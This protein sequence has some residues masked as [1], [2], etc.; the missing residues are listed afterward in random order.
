MCALSLLTREKIVV[1][2]AGWVIAGGVLPGA[3]PLKKTCTVRGAEEPGTVKVFLVVQLVSVL[4][5]EGE[6]DARGCLG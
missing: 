3:L 6:K 5:A 2:M 4:D 1:E